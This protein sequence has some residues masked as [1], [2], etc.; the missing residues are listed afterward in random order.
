LSFSQ[1]S[2]CFHVEL[3]NPLLDE[4]QLLGQHIGE[5]H[6]PTFDIGFP[7]IAN[8]FGELAVIRIDKPDFA[9][10][11]IFLWARVFSSLSTIHAHYFQLTVRL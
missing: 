2:I 5:V 4:A 6:I 11:G 7:V 1:P 9:L 10:R 8:P 3:Y